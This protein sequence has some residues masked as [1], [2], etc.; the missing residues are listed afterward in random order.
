MIVVNFVFFWNNVILLIYDFFGT[1]SSGA[2]TGVPASQTPWIRPWS[3]HTVEETS[4]TCANLIRIVRII[5][6]W[7]MHLRR[8]PT[9]EDS[10]DEL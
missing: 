6:F 2:Q 3:V 5:Y 4:Q 7:E 8:S 1:L 10:Y 9:I